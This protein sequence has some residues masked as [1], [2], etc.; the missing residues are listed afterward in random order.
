MTRKP[1]V[2]AL[3][4]IR[5]GGVEYVKREHFDIAKH[6]AESNRQCVVEMQKDRDVWRNK[7]LRL[8]NLRKKRT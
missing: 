2:V 5:L 7:Y 6:A 1:P 3:P 8:L 4:M